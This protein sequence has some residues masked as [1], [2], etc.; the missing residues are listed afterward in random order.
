M[1]KIKW[2]QQAVIYIYIYIYIYIFLSV[3]I[4]VYV[5]I[6][7]KEEV[8]RLR[9]SGDHGRSWKGQLWDGIDVNIVFM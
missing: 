9:G 5:T 4:Y 3:C 6:V 8:M 2:T 1:S 7:I